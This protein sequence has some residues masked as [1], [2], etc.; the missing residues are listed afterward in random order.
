[1]KAKAVAFMLL[2]VLLT[3]FTTPVYADGDPPPV[4]IPH[5]FYGT[6]EVNGDL[7]PVGTEVEARG[8]GVLT[9]V[10]GNPVV[11]IAYGKYGN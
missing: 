6:V 4:P 2:A 11:I 7:A 8:N 5:A 10:D 9:G 3:L 1:M